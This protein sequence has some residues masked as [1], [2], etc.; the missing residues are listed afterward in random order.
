[1]FM[2]NSQQGR[3][4]TCRRSGRCMY[5]KCLR[6]PA[7]DGWRGV[8]SGLVV[9]RSRVASSARPL[10]VCSMA[11]CGW[12]VHFAQFGFLCMQR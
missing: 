3:L 8:P 12:L 7:I 11:A 2:A 4:M 1:M 6:T 10:R 9:R 5:L